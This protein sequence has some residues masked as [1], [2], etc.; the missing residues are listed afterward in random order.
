[1]N[2]TEWL[3]MVAEVAAGAA[4]GHPVEYAY[5]GCNGWYPK[6]NNTGFLE[7]ALYRIKP[8]TFTVNG[9]KVQEPMREA[10]DYGSKYFVVDLT[11]ESLTISETWYNDR[12]SRRWLSR[13]ICHTTKEAAIA[14]AKSMLGIDPNQQ[15]E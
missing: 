11:V 10:P 8:R 15:E 1:M 9:F 6:D 13:G 2:N 3:K 5:Q 7:G 14:H 12:R 4:E